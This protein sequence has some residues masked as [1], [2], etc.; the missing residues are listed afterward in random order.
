MSDG[1]TILEK[2]IHALLDMQKVSHA[3]MGYPYLLQAVMSVCSDNELRNAR[4]IMPVYSAVAKQAN[5]LPSRVERSIRAAL[6]QA[7]CKMTGSQFTF[8]AAD[9]LCSQVHQ[10]E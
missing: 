1:Y 3:F 4:K 7:N 5:V 9:T 2:D 6:K 10:S 8:W